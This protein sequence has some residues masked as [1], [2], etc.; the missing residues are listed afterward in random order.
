MIISSLFSTDNHEIGMGTIQKASRRQRQTS[1]NVSSIHI[2]IK[3]VAPGDKYQDI[4]H[5]NRLSSNSLNNPATLKFKRLLV[6][7]STKFYELICH[8]QL[9]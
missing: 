4:K 6:H 3:V 1:G 9:N 5:P 8:I 2:S 7:P